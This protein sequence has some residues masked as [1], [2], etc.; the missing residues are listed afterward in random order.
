MLRLFVD[1]LQVGDQAELPP[2]D[3][4]ELILN[5]GQYVQRLARDD[6]AL[7][8]KTKFCQLCETIVAQTEYIVLSNE[9]RFRNAV[10]EWL[11]D[12]SYEGL[13]VFTPSEW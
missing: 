3:L 9:A 12:W 2:V 5:L 6:R 1:R 11:Y 10:L 4:G 7:R 13:K 8:M